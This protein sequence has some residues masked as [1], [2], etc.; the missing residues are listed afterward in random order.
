M[1]NR[2]IALQLYTVRDETARDFQA[3]IRYVA[4]LGYDA[5]EFAGYGNLSADEM[6][7]LLT[8]T[9]LRVAGTHVGW[10]ALENNLED[11]IDY[12]LAIGSR[13]IT[14]PYL[15]NEWYTG[16]KFKTL[17]P[18]LNKF[19]RIAQEKGLTFSY[20]N[21]AHEFVQGEDGR[22]LLDMLLDSTDPAYV[23]LELDTY[24]AA[25]AGVDPIAYLHKRAGRVALIHLKDMTPERTFTEV[26]DG[27]LNTVGI[28]QAAE[29][30]GV[31]WYIIENDAP[32]LPSLN[33]I[34]RSLANLRKI[35]R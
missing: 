29:E 17:A 7:A 9:G 16:E 24:W 27:I 22:Y 32:A 3:T 19:G 15:G 18:Q 13:N 26:G 14:L 5:V 6:V 25:Y 21:H 33:S 11:Q 20:H 31:E 28:C 35:L 34:E 30:S 1:S 4:K 2:S 10:D 12:C 8:E 23:K